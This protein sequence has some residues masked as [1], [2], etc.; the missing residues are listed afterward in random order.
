M[1]LKKEILTLKGS[2]MPMS[3]PTKDDIEQVKKEKEIE[4]VTAD[5]LPRE[6]VSNII[7]NALSNYKVTDMKEGFMVQTIAQWLLDDNRGELS[8]LMMNFLKDKVLHSA[9]VRVEDE[10]VDKEMK[11]VEKGSYASWAI[12]QVIDELNV[13]DEITK[14][15]KADNKKEE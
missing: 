4:T 2:T 1:N 5:E 6:T 8:K 12:I 7:L 15:A 10:M 14:E 13:P 3:F 11:K 9:M